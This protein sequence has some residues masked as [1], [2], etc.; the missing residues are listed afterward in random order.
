MISAGLYLGGYGSHLWLDI[1]NV[2]GID[3]FWPSPIRVV[4]P[5]RT[6]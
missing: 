6:A 3:L 2:R 4:M 5:G 1:L